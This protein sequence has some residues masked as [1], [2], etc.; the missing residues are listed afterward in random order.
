MY[1]LKSFRE[2]VK[3]YCQRVRL[4]GAQRYTL[5]EL[6]A[7]VG[8]ARAEFSRRLNGTGGTRL[9]CANA[10]AITVELIRQNAITRR[11]DADRL[12]ALLGCPPL[13]DA[14]LRGLL[15]AAPA[16]SQQSATEVPNNLP[17]SLTTFI[18]RVAELQ[19]CSSL[20]TGGRLL[21]I[22]G[23]GGV[24][25]TRFALELAAQFRG[26][27]F[28]LYPDGIWLL[29]LQV[30]DLAHA[31]QQLTAAVA[32]HLGVMEQASR[33]LLDTLLDYLRDRTLLLI[34]DNCEH[35]RSAA[36]TLVATL[37][38][39]CT[40]ISIVATSRE[41]LGVAG[42]INWQ[43]AP[44]PVPTLPEPG[45]TPYL[46][47]LRENEAVRLF[48]NRAQQVLAER[49]F[50]LT[51]VNAATIAAICVQ[52]EGIP[53]A[54]EL[55]AARVRWLP[56][57]TILTR[58]HNQLRTLR[59]DERDPPNQQ[60]TLRGSIA[61]SYDLLNVAEQKLFA[62][63]AVFNGGCSLEAAEEVCGT[64]EEDDLID[65]LGSLVN[66]S[67][68]LADVDAGRYRML[69][70]IRQFAAEKLKASGMEAQLRR[71]HLN[72][73]HKLVVEAG[74]HLV[75]PAAASSL[76]QLA[77]EQ[78]NLRATLTW[79]QSEDPPLLLDLSGLLGRFWHLHGDL[80]GGLGWLTAAVK[81][82]QPASVALVRALNWAA[83]LCRNQGNLN[84]AQSYPDRALPLGKQVGD[85][86]VL[87]LTLTNLGRLAAAGGDYELARQH[88][89]RQL[90]ISRQLADQWRIAEVLQDLGTCAAHAGD[91]VGRY[92]CCKRLLP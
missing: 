30:L 64:A 82:E 89:T 75:G 23:P 46:G 35:I 33:P 9:T 36:A 57:D 38:S 47:G 41:P 88:F 60:Q 15:L 77:Q 50:D 32:A 61:W 85:P 19:Q 78:A 67:L 27:S 48:V 37:L 68:L 31:E 8:L 25:K 44:L 90:P 12:I 63:L 34:F 76:A 21:T 53:L 73:F 91:Y 13:A 56:L 5:G 16:T 59:N 24:G 84:Q 65:L 79:A 7:A 28:S 39:S 70:V 26:R 14:D 20:L 18:G 22:T 71:S 74:P 55:A 66:K 1:D 2:Q 83:I 43:L 80:S 62:R 29:T 86:D 6:A 17:L 58:L 81:G 11:A 87:S 92:R 54:L 45:T 51:A 4:G 10:Q 42:E 69:E 3:G 52:L 40:G 72:Y 49:P